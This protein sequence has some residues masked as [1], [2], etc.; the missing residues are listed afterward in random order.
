MEDQL[1][2]LSDG[3][4]CLN[5]IITQEIKQLM[6][7]YRFFRQEVKHEIRLA[8]KLHMCTELHNSKENSNPIWNGNEKKGAFENR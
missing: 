5:L 4:S 6:N 3:S 8:E 1:A 7:A 2:E